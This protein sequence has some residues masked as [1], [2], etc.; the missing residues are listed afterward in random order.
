MKSHDQKTPAE[1]QAEIDAKVAEIMG[2][3]YSG[4][5]EKTDS[6]FRSGGKYTKTYRGKKRTDRQTMAQ[7]RTRLF[8]K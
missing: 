3:D 2:R 1:R 4:V 5:N 7:A 8:G 6:T